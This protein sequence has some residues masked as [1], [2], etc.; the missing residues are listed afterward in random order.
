MIEDFEKE[1]DEKLKIPLKKKW[2]KLKPREKD[3]Q[4]DEDKEEE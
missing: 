4:L 1:T 3:D 2:N